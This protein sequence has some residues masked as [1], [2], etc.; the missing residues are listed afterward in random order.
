MKKEE[1]HSYWLNFIDGDTLAFRQLYERYIDEL[2]T[3]GCRYSRD[4]NLVK[5]SIHDL[6]IDLHI[7]IKII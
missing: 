7:L 3:F 5:A 4:R 2:Y 1:L 6:S